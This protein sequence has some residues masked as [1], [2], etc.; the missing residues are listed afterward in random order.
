MGTVAITVTSVTTRFY[1][2]ITLVIRPH[3]RGWL[4]LRAML[5][6]VWVCLL[7]FPLAGS[8]RS[9]AQQ[10][11][12][13]ADGATI[14]V[15]GTVT[16]EP[17]LLNGQACRAVIQT[18]TEGIVIFTRKPSNLLGAFR[19]G[20]EVRIKGTFSHYKGMPELEP[21]AIK[22]LSHDHS[23]LAQ[24]LGAQSITSLKAGTLVTVQ[25]YVSQF[26]TQR[27]MLN[28]SSEEGMVA[29]RIPRTFLFRRELKSWLQAGK[30][31]KATGIVW[32][33]DTM[34]PSHVFLFPRDPGDIAPEH[35]WISPVA[36]YSLFAGLSGVVVLLLV[37][38]WMRATRSN[39]RLQETL[40]A[41]NEAQAAR[42]Q[43]E[44]HFSTALQLSNIANCYFDARRKK[45]QWW[46]TL[47]GISHPTT[48][49]ELRASSFLDISKKRELARALRGLS[50]A[51]GTY[52]TSLAF[53]SKDALT[54]NLAIEISSIHDNSGH[55]LLVGSVID[56]TH[57]RQLEASLEQARS[58]QLIARISMGFS[59]NFNNVLTAISGHAE[60]L[61]ISGSEADRKHRAGLIRTEVMRAASLSRE[62]MSLSPAANVEKT[63]LDLNHHLKFTAEK[64][65]AI[66]GTP[67]RIFLD[68]GK[69]QVR[70]VSEQLCRAFGAA[71]RNA[72]ESVAANGGGITVTSAIV[73]NLV[74]VSIKDEGEGMTE[75]VIR[76]AFDPFF[77]TKQMPGSFGLGLS[78]AK[79][80]IEGYGGT[81]KIHS[82]V[83]GG[84]SVIITL[85]RA[86]AF[87]TER[88]HLLANT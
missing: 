2:Q 17:T 37:R 76:H 69:P 74:E 25:G 1:D 53:T 67:L 23:V 45:M 65:V 39:R 36:L 73:Q 40:Q 50:K 11:A 38:D 19:E 46:N 35:S 79:V 51:P 10:L 27:G 56:V 78:I 88:S 28:L 72:T 30:R 86:S 59:H 6:R 7:V 57:L 33:D 58:A 70:A 71:L 81:I 68:P 64:E 34:E 63:P 87:I 26:N 20:D 84:T 21:Q 49:K 48:L 80:I 15:Q 8:V 12:N 43:D 47:K 75:E 61:E 52:C 3:L 62:I 29:V 42:A 85:P 55:L 60:L 22:V 31:V 66:K 83:G 16:Q 24:P 5:F 32:I 4:Y 13:A 82:Q 54:R 18:P 14:E 9:G 44:L 77:T 41:L